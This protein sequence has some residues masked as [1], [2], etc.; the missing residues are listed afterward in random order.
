[1]FVFALLLVFASV[2]VLAAALLSDGGLEA[3]VLSEV[4][5]LSVSASQL[6]VGESS[7]SGRWLG[8]TLPFA[9]GSAGWSAGSSGFTGRGL[10]KRSSSL[11]SAEPGSLDPP[12][13]EVVELAESLFVLG[14][15]LLVAG[16]PAGPGEAVFWFVLVFEAG[17]AAA[18]PLFPPELAKELKPPCPPFPPPPPPLPDD[19]PRPDPAPG[20]ALAIRDCRPMS[21]RDCDSHCS[22]RF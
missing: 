20:P 3:E 21:E 2:L 4:A 12:A 15:A 22:R 17:A 13:V 1:M 8:A 7:R 10:I 16:S 9:G 6:V 19:A 18:A 11:E 14:V 5:E